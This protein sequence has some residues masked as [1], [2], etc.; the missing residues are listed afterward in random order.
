MLLYAPP[1]YT[2]TMGSTFIPPPVEKAVAEP[3]GSW[4]ELLR[5]HENS[6][7]EAYR[8]RKKY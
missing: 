2:E 4:I 1:K 8:K 5:R 7:Y 3:H 6:V